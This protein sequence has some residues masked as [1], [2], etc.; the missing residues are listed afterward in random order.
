VWFAPDA[1][2]LP[3]ASLFAIMA[4][5]AGHVVDLRKPGRWFWVDGKPVFEEFGSRSKRQIARWHQREDDHIERI[6]DAIAEAVFGHQIGYT[7]TR[8]CLVQT[9]SRGR[10]RPEGLK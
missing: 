3:D 2:L 5:E 4:H 6:A 10:S 9:F 7:G 8:S 1:V